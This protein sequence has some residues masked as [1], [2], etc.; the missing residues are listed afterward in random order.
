MDAP[1]IFDY[2][3]KELSQ[4]ALIC[5][6]VACAGEATGVYRERG[7]KFISA[8]WTHDRNSHGEQ[9]DVTDVGKPSRQYKNID[10]YFQA[11]I[12]QKTVS[13]VIEDKINTQMHSGQLKRYLSEIGRDNKPEDEIRAIYFKTGY[14]YDEERERAETMKFSVFDASDMQVFLE[15]KPISD[16]HEILRQYRRHLEPLIEDRETKLQ[17]WDLNMDFVQWEFLKRLRDCLENR[18][19]E[20]NRYL[21]ESFRE[22][23]EADWI[24]KG[25][26]RWRNTGGGAWTQYRFTKY[27]HWRLD[28]GYPLRFR[29][30]TEAARRID[31]GF[32]AEVWGK[33]INAFKE[34][35]ETHE[36]PA[37]TFQRRMKYRG[38]LASEGTVGTID[39]EKLLQNKSEDESL[40]RIVQ[41]HMSFLRRVHEL[42]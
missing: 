5:W 28:A 31:K 10:V 3:T 12:N 25:L 16:D 6:L 15:Q 37:R 29:V 7:L 19:D 11:T 27:F 39:I 41:F 8:L 21:D 23:D 34:T 32:D 18:R 9:C 17:Q 24:W 33:W 30:S 35:Q 2:A 26:A 40:E 13:F 22:A 4:D 36:L 20:W 1:N 42:S 38:E 14:V